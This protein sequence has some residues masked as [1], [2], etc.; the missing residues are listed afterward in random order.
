MAGALG[1]TNKTLSVSPSV[2]RPDYR[3]ISEYHIQSL[4]LGKYLGVSVNFT[5]VIWG[6]C[7]HLFQGCC[8]LRAKQS[9]GCGRRLNKSELL[10]VIG[11]VL[12]ILSLLSKI[13]VVTFGILYQLWK[14][15]Q[16]K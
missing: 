6:R 3:N 9:L 15:N 4:T 2:E 16:S 13:H 1:P 5:S 11:L 8:D 12:F 7:Q 10:L 14:Q